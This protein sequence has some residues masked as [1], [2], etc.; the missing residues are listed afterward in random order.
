MK[1]FFK[2]NQTRCGVFPL[3]L[4]S[5]TKRIFDIVCLGKKFFIRKFPIISNKLQL[6]N[7]K[8]GL[9]RRVKELSKSNQTRYAVSPVY[10]DSKTKKSFCY[11]LHRK[12]VCFSYGNLRISRRKKFKKIGL[13]HLVKELFKS[14]QTRHGVS[15]V[16]LK[17]KT[18]RISAIACLG[19]HL[20]F[21][22]ETSNYF[23]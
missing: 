22:T 20:V 10:C 3:Y 12:K 13:F 16:Y 5:K 2:S 1:E 19:R 7:F 4:D 23:E 8:I 9:F 15:P 11:S 14:N 21:H 17:F 18:K 6:S